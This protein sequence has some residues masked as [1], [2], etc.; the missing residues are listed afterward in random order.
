MKRLIF[1]LCAIIL[2]FTACDNGKETPTE[3]PTPIHSPST[4]LTPT[5]IPVPTPTYKLPDGMQYIGIASDKTN[6]L[7]LI[8]NLYMTF[9]Y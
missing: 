8:Y 6:G 1:I 3:S 7:G 5:P 4:A 9:Q 2:L